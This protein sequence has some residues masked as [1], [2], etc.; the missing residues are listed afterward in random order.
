MKSDDQNKNL[1]THRTTSIK[2]F[3]SKLNL[4]IDKS[5]IAAVNLDL[6]TESN[7]TDPGG[8]SQ[9]KKANKFLVKLDMIQFRSPSNGHSLPPFSR[10]RLV[11]LLQ[12]FLVMFLKRNC[13]VTIESL[14]KKG[15]RFK[16]KQNDVPLTKDFGS[17]GAE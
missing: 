1:Q 10:S 8:N 13:R 3:A 11:I 9:L 6:D 4:L 16:T 14:H 7:L 15:Y 17:L 12:T 5:L 2:R